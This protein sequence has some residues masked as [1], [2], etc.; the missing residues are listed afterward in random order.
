MT[1][2]SNR[3]WEQ[4]TFPIPGCHLLLWCHECKCNRQAE[5]TKCEHKKDKN[6]HRMLSK[7]NGKCIISIS[8][9]IRSHNGIICPKVC[10][11]PITGTYRW[12]RIFSFGLHMDLNPY[13]AMHF[14]NPVRTTKKGGRGSGAVVCRFD[15]RHCLININITDTN[16]LC[17][18]V[19][20]R[21]EHYFCIKRDKKHIHV[22]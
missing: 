1:A 13:T 6:T 3:K 8:T 11:W 14:R 10:S 21:E 7:S 9:V 15:W 17:Y 12:A 16:R 20:G 19:Q 5:H 4:T 18:D 22:Y 2:E